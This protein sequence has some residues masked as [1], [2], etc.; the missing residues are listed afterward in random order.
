MTIR[1]YPNPQPYE[2]RQTS[3]AAMISRMA[4]FIEK[5]TG[6]N[7]FCPLMHCMG[8]SAGAGAGIRRKGVGKGGSQ[9]GS[10]FLISFSRH[11]KNFYQV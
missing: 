7:S 6:A 1:V 11:T 4:I 2:T 5:R 10:D 8:E 3:A 9:N